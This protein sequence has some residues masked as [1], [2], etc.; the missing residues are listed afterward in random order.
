[1]Q[2]GAQV[3]ALTFQMAAT[4]D[5]TV[6]DLGNGHREYSMVCNL[7]SRADGTFVGQ[8][9]GTA[10]TME[11]KW[12]YRTGPLE[13][14]GVPVPQDYWKFRKDDPAKALEAIGGK[15]NVAKKNPDTGMWEIA[16][17][18]EKVE[19]DNPADTW[20]TVRKM[21]AKRAFVHAV[22]NTT[23]ASDM[24]TQ[25]LDDLPVAVE[26]L[27]DGFRNDVDTVPSQEPPVPSQTPEA[28]QKGAKGA[29]DDTEAPVRYECTKCGAKGTAAPDATQ[30]DLADM[31]CPEC[32]DTALKAAD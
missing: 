28:P 16:V 5:E 30:A 31:R 18:G 2:P 1:M 23:A 17:A 4:F 20:N 27:P 21:A 13:F 7:A 25:D 10:S 19:H 22:L 11:S 6:N 24:F 12:R 8:G 9:I 3:L 29:N 14:T 32:L 26:D 15:G